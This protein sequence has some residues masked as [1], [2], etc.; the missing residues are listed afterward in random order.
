MGSPPEPTPSELVAETRSLQFKGNSDLAKSTKFLIQ[1]RE[2]LSHYR[3]IDDLVLDAFDPEA[4]DRQLDL[5][6]AKAMVHHLTTVRAAIARVVWTRQMFI[7]ISVL[8]EL[9]FNSVRSATADTDDPVL[10]VFETIVAR[11]LFYPGVVVYPLYGFGVL[12]AG[13]IKVLTSTH[14]SLLASEFGFVVSPQ[15]NSMQATI[16]FLNDA[17]ELL[18]VRKPVPTESLEHWQRSRPAQWL[19][20]NPLLV[21]RVTSVPGD[22][23]ENQFLLL[24]RLRTI[25][26]FL[27]MLAARQDVAPGPEETVFSSARINNFQTLDIK[28]YMVLSDVPADE[29][30]LYGDFVPM[31]ASV[32]ALAELSDLPI[33]FYPD[34]W[35]GNLVD[36][37]RIYE[38]VNYV[39]ERGLETSFGPPGETKEAQ[40]YRKLAR[41]LVHFRRSFSTSDEDWQGTLSLA[42]AFETLL[43]DGYSAGVRSRVSRRIRLLLSDRLDVESLAKEVEQMYSRR[44]GLM[45]GADVDGSGRN[46]KAQA[47]FVDTFVAVAERLPSMMPLAPPDAP[48]RYICGDNTAPPAASLLGDLL[49]VFRKHFRRSAT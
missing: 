19:T 5:K 42:I 14:L 17:C 43:T 8:D 6:D 39:Y 1:H 20:R 3:F 29:D 9:L 24:D 37:R 46:Q 31:N 44:G 28:H 16:A 13:L 45:H 2:R 4:V 12:G 27:A 30:E 48:L 15:T 47:V 18:G 22:Y 33:E 25:A 40:V 41:S 49:E 23:Y 26:S 36:A 7:G 32:A 34:H 10:Q 35:I 21:A 38:A 11:D